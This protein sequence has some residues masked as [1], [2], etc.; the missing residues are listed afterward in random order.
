M[1][2]RIPADPL[3]DAKERVRE[4]DNRPPLPPAV[5]WPFYR[6]VQNVRRRK[7]APKEPK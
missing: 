2:D 3:A 1:S 4:I 6:A 5:L 7:A